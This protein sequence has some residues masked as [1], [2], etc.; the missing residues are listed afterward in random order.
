[1]RSEFF[2]RMMELFAGDRFSATLK[3]NVS[4]DGAARE[5]SSISIKG[6]RKHAMLLCPEHNC[7]GLL[8]E[9]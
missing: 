6:W 2:W 5:K 9:L 3:S 1:M 4:L 8:V 7:S